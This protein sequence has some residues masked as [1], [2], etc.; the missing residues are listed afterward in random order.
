MRLEIENGICTIITGENDEIKE[1][2]VNFKATV[3]FQDGGTMEI[4]HW[5]KTKAERKRKREYFNEHG[6]LPE[7]EINN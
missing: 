4:S 2:L 7:I 1:R 5:D 3:E 6:E